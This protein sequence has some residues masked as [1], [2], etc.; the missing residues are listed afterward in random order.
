MKSTGIARE[1]DKLG[2]VVLPVELRRT[3]EI[4]PGDLV[5]FYTEGNTIILK[6][7]AKECHFCGKDSSLHVFKG[8][9]IC[10]E[11]IDEIKKQTEPKPFQDNF[12]L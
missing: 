4:N 10:Q 3:L 8:R 5:E 11:C 12:N 9:N 6:K 2:R 1:T 7:Q